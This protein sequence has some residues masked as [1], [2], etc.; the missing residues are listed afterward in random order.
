MYGSKL[1]VNKDTRG[2]LKWFR[3]RFSRTSTVMLLLPTMRKEYT[4]NLKFDRVFVIE[5]KRRSLPLGGL[6]LFIHPYG[7]YFNIKP[8]HFMSN[9]RIYG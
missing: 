7:K 9:K 3:V 5:R 8:H 4:H 2:Y 1:H 6:A